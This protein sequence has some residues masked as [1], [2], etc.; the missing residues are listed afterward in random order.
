MK[1]PISCGEKNE[2]YCFPKKPHI[3][4]QQASVFRFSE[5]ETKTELT[6]FCSNAEATTGAHIKVAM[7]KSKFRGYLK[8][9][10]L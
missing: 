3:C 2:Y 1:I 8:M 10:G 9:K 5:N 7:L 6:D 4:K